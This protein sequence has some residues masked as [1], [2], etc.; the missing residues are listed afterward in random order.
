M[1][2]DVADMF[3]DHA[4][5]RQIG[6]LVVIGAAKQLFFHL[7][8]P[9][10]VGGALDSSTLRSPIR[11]RTMRGQEHAPVAFGIDAFLEYRGAAGLQQVECSCASM[12]QC[13]HQKM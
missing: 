3:L 13:L 12:R 8:L 4:P 5:R 7:L 6:Q 9:A 1:A 10:H 11:D 2:N